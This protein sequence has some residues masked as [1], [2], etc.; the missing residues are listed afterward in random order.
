MLLNHA[1]SNIVNSG[2]LGVQQATIDMNPTIMHVLSRDLY[3]RPIEAVVRE[4]LTNA[5]DAHVEAGTTH[6]PVDI[7][8]PN[9][10]DELFYI[11]DYGPGLSVERVND[12]YLVYGKSTRRES[13]E[14]SGAFGLGCKASLA[15]TTSFMVTSYH[16]GQKHEFLVYYD[17]DN[18]PCL[19]HRSSEPSTE[20]SGLKVSLSMLNGVDYA[21]FHSAVT[22]ILQHIPE[23][24]YNCITNGFS[25]TITYPEYT[26]YASLNLK[27]NKTG[28][29]QIIM[30]Y[31]AYDVD[32]GSVLEYLMQHN[33]QLHVNEL[34]FSATDIIRTLSNTYDV[35]IKAELG[36]YPIHPSREFINITPRAVKHLLEDISE[37]I[38]TLAQ[39]LDDSL[40]SD[41]LFYRLTRQVPCEDFK[42]RARLITPSSG[43]WSVTG[44][45]SQ[46]CQSYSQLLSTIHQAYSYEQNKNK[47][48]TVCRLNSPD[49]VDFVGNNRRSFSYKSTSDK[50]IIVFIDEPNS[51][52]LLPRIEEI[53]NLNFDEEVAKVRREAVD[54]AINSPRIYR[55][56]QPTRSIQDPSHNVL[57]FVGEDGSRKKDWSSCKHNV[58][59]LQGLGRNI[60]WVPTRMG[61]VKD[62]DPMRILAKYAKIN[63]II[64]EY[65]RPIIIGLPATKGTMQ[66]QQAFKPLVELDQWLEEFA[67]SPY[68]V[69]RHMLFSAYLTI[70][71]IVNIEHLAHCRDYGWADW[72]YR[73]YMTGKKYAATNMH[74]MASLNNI[75]IHGEFII[76]VCKDVISKFNY[77]DRNLWHCIARHHERNWPTELANLLKC[78]PTS[79]K[80][81]NQEI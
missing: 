74:S 71:G 59:S 23:E 33:K 45:V 62:A 44:Y 43:N 61:C 29:F 19:D 31:V 63:H 60:F 35:A 25:L 78:Y 75:Q 52:Y 38:Q 9:W 69:R 42:L 37:G 46:L 34:T 56:I 30:G 17:Q 6:I 81:K 51:E 1:K 7:K 27:S 5:L 76:S 11:R 54:A 50:P 16:E 40:H 73:V 20:P 21:H 72:L 55:R 39:S 77:V 24:Y 57:Q 10:D 28:S 41:L 3:Q 14:Y 12:L 2:S 64:P 53:D 68:F 47:E 26:K 22:K 15:Y 65:K 67:N 49:F 80:H 48:L 18:I 58:Q 79:A 4:T 36:R 8:L 66:I 13:N 70:D 32:V